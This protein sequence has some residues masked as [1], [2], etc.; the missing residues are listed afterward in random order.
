MNT[1]NDANGEHRHKALRFLTAGSVDD[2][3]ST[4]IG[5]LLLDSRAILADQLDA[6]QR[7]ATG[8]GIDLSQL[9]DGLEAEREQGIT[10]DVAYRY[11]TTPRRKFIIADAPG[12]EQ[13]TRNMVTAAA[14]SDAAVVLIDITKLDWRAAPMRLLPQTRRHTL[15][16]R[17]LRLP[18]IVFA[19]NKL[20]AV[21]DAEAAFVAVRGALLEFAAKAGIAPAGIV[22]VSALRGDNIAIAQASW[23]WYTGP[24]L[25][26]L[27][28]ALHAVEEPQ[29]GA[30]LLPL[31]YVARE[32]DGLG[33]QPRTVWGRIARGQVRS[34]DK[35]R[36]HP[37]GETAEVV[38]VR[39]AGVVVDGCTAG[40]SAGLVL[41]RQIDVSRG[42]WVIGLEPVWAGA[43]VVK[44][45]DTQRHQSSEPAELPQSR[46]S[47]ALSRIPGGT[48][49]FD[50]TLAWLDTEPAVIGRKYW[51]R[52]G[53][54]WVAG[55]ITAI[56]SRLDI[57]TLTDVDAQTL[58]VNDIGRVRLQ[59]QSVLPLEIFA[60][61]RVAGA[62][63]VVD[64]ATH[65]T[66]GALMVEA[67]A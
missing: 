17:L 62:M 9:T 18:S 43:A 52:H 31:Q 35:V 49:E 12:H 37:S 3:K 50:A 46:V 22:P 51:L 20:D 30:L 19:V 64:P 33:H 32:G 56:S 23:P 57:H 45:G 5:R 4:L 59:V 27:L 25:L 36:I 2:G 61:N 11:F 41:D 40:Q 16:A 47:S 66:S 53:H 39:R 67:L 34:G 42:D 7:R 13:Y 21:D 65:R 44:P 15:L 1:H 29:T 24:T 58:A 14:G 55:H 6:L 28:E 26:Q 63:I 10:I 54:R 48:Q 60:D 38:T 8:G